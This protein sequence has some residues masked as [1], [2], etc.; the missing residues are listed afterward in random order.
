MS[1]FCL[2]EDYNYFPLVPL[3]RTL[4]AQAQ[5][6]RSYSFPYGVYANVQREKR[7]IYYMLGYA[8]RDLCTAPY[9]YGGVVL[10]R[11]EFI[12]IC[13]G[14]NGNPYYSWNFDIPPDQGKGARC[15]SNASFGGLVENST[16]PSPGQRQFVSP[17]FR[18]SFEDVHGWRR[19][20]DR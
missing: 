1:R 13:M 15:S 3:G 8:K 19:Q 17:A 16:L 4:A 5:I 18:S 14:K 10:Q 2:L 20:H 12:K 7:D 6:A 11:F 9:R